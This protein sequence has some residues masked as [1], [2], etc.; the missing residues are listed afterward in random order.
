[1]KASIVERFNITLKGMMWKEFSN[2]GTYHWIDIYKILLKTY[3][4]NIHR[5]IKMAPSNVNS[6]HEKMLLTTAYNNLK[7]FKPS[8]IHVGDC[9][10]VN[11]SQTKHI[12]LV[13]TNSLFLV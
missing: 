10:N 4:E 11:V 12:N 9:I 6:S 13:C 3:N 2:N 1:M 8:R 5:T 7:I